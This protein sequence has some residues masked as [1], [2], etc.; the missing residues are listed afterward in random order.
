MNIEELNKM[1]SPYV[2]NGEM[3][4]DD[5]DKIFGFLPRKEQ[6]P[7]AYTIED[8]LKILLVDEII[9]LPANKISEKKILEKVPLIFR[10]AKEIKAS[11]KILIQLIQ[12]GDLQARQDLCI[13]NQG[14]VAKFTKYYWEKFP[15]SLELEDLIQE[16]NIG[17][18]KA[19]ERFDF[20]R[21]TEFSTYATQWIIQ[22][23]TRA[24]ADT[25]QIIRLPV[26]ILE[27]IIK[28]SRLERI[29]LI[30]GFDLR[31]RIELIAREMA[32]TPEEISRFFSLRTIYLNINSLDKPIDEE[33]EI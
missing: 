20:A 11:N 23:I 7:I 27:K 32:T 19:A 18:L 2:V 17:M 1:I 5:F 3:T 33:N 8:D 14:L 24:I 21:G 9:S 22:A 15:C 13:K 26:H 6:Y 28:A 4:Y 31:R 25:G 30:Q 29:F 12:S 10:E 16:A